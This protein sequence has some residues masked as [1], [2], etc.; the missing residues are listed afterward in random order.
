MVAMII[1]PLGYQTEREGAQQLIHDHEVK[2]PEDLP[3][4]GCAA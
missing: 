2:E 1:R 3:S 4:K